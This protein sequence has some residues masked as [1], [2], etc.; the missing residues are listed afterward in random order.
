MPKIFPNRTDPNAIVV[1]EV[2]VSGGAFVL[3]KK[4]W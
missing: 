2:W 1:V 3:G 4:R